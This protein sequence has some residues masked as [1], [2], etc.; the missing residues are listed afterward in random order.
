MN[1]N[2]WIIK[3]QRNTAKNS[4]IKEE[5]EKIKDKNEIDQPT[6]EYLLINE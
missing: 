3:T 5:K 4:D 6:E 1:R 2:H